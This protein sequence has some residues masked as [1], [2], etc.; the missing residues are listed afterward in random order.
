MNLD[1]NFNATT[2]L[3]AWWIQVKSN[4][5]TIQNWANNLENKGVTSSHLA[6]MSVTTSKIAD[7]NVTEVKIADNAVTTSKLANG[8]VTSEKLGAYAVT[9][10]KINVSA[11][12]N[13]TIAPK[14]V[15]TE[16]IADENVTA[17]KLASG[18]VT[19]EKISSGAVTS[20]KVADKSITTAKIADDA[21]TKDK[22]ADNAIQYEHIANA[23]VDNRNIAANAVRTTQLDDDAVTTPK[24]ADKAITADK[25]GANAVTA[26]KLAKNSV[27]TDKI[28]AKAITK[29]KLAD[30]I[31][32]EA[33]GT[34]RTDAGEIAIAPATQE[35]VDAGRNDRKPITPATLKNVLD[36]F[37]MNTLITELPVE[38]QDTPLTVS[39]HV[40]FFPQSGAAA[41]IIDSKWD[42]FDSITVD[43]FYW[44]ST[45]G[46]ISK[47][48][49]ALLLFK[50]NPTDS[51]TNS[52]GS[53]DIIRINES[54]GDIPD[55]SIGIEKLTANAKAA[56][57]GEK[58]DK[59][60]AGEQG[61]QGNPGCNASTI[62]VA[63]ST[64]RNKKQA[65]YIC[66]GTNDNITI[67]NAIAALPSAGGKIVLLE[68]TYN[69]S[70]QIK[71]NK[72]NVTIEG[73][74]RNNTALDFGGLDSTAVNVTS[75][76]F[77]IRGI[78]IANA[79]VGL[80]L[81]AINNCTIDDI[82]ASGCQWTVNLGSGS[83]HMVR[84]VYSHDNRLGIYGVSSGCIITGCRCVD[85]SEIGIDI[86]GKRN[87]VTNNYV[88]R[89]TGQASDYTSSQYTIR[90]QSSGQYN[91]VSDNYILGKNYTN[92]G[93]ST[94]TFNNNRYQ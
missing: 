68:G 82:E 25:I 88:I 4:L 34:T 35:E 42:T 44:Y 54:G 3:K 89:G 76:N 12:S 29:E 85:N 31:T 91:D 21:I 51:G 30:D 16:K 81:N 20:D 86:G 9:E 57:K 83:G 26:D 77:V 62:V 38:N 15:T 45:A 18:A 93:D 46:G 72:P 84:N 47:G 66:T 27:T 14:A 80:Y 28:P 23:A 41:Y 22:I 39:V 8:S 2:K 73:M 32:N 37:S 70:G 1:F 56:L 67:S 61:P 94:N 36:K 11:V 79:T 6:D 90:I 64:S 50:S 78:S 48:D 63:S 40:D 92:S 58:G 49:T 55:G 60:A 53:F 71:V 33:Y 87:K 13:R 19:S 7:G 52:A 65:D 24:I 69:C 17:A 75:P 10:T 59:G 74:G 5:T 43:D